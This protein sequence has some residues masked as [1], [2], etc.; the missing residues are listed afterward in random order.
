VAKVVKVGVLLESYGGIVEVTV[1]SDGVRIRDQCPT[2]SEEYIY[3]FEPIGD[4]RVITSYR[5]LA[6]LLVA[7]ILAA[8]IVRMLEFLYRRCIGST[9][10]GATPK[11]QSIVVQTID[12]SSNG[13]SSDRFTATKSLP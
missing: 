6:T 10:S 4:S 11:M 9:Q 3:M 7:V 13:S 1:I 8:L 2:R 12:M 5:G